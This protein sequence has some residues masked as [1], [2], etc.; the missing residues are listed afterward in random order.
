MPSLDH[1]ITI[2]F[3]YH[4]AKIERIFEPT[5]IPQATCQIGIGGSF[6]DRRYQLCPNQRCHVR[7]PAN[8]APEGSNWCRQREGYVFCL[9][10]SQERATLSMLLRWCFWGS[11]VLDRCSTRR[12]LTAFVEQTQIQ[13]AQRMHSRTLHVLYWLVFSLTG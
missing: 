10:F 11:S 7:V 4:F 9:Y 8:Y 2:A 6:V 5:G 12:V 1:L 3:D 13:V